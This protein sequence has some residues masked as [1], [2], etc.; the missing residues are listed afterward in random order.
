MRLTSRWVC[1][2]AFVERNNNKLPGFILADAGFDVWLGN[3]RGGYYGLR[4]LNKQ[5][6]ES[7]FWDFS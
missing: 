7:A 4:H 6:D 1:F 3:S 2:A 5:A